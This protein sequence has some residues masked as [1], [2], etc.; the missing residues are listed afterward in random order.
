MTDVPEKI[1][2]GSIRY[3]EGDLSGLDLRV[4]GDD[5][6]VATDEPPTEYV[7]ADRHVK[8]LA[9]DLLDRLANPF[10]YASMN[11]GSVNWQKTYEAMRRALAEDGQMPS[12]LMA[13]LIEIS[14][15]DPWDLK[16]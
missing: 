4:W 11:D 8:E 3:L 12:V 13:A 2:A 16:K 10:H 15:H 5:P 9:K 14:G 1:W 7:L 6:R